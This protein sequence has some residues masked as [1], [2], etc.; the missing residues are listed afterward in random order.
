LV[1]TEPAHK[2]KEEEV[3]K[4]SKGWKVASYI[5]FVVIVGLILVNIFG[6][7][8]GARID[9]SPAK[10]IAVLVFYNNSGNT[11]WTHDHNTP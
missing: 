11:I 4:S 3:L 2:V 8:R 5:S 10:S 9:E 1:K 6:R 7:N